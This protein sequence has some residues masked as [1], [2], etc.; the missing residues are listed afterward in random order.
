MNKYSEFSRHLQ[1]LYIQLKKKWPYQAEETAQGSGG[2][3]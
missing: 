2:Q 3:N 1:L